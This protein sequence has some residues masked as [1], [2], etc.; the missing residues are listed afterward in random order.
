MAR[1][2]VL[3]RGAPV[4]QRSLTAVGTSLMASGIAMARKPV[5]AK[6][7]SSTPLRERRRSLRVQQPD[8]W[9]KTLRAERKTTRYYRSYSGPNITGSSRFANDPFAQKQYWQ[10]KA[11]AKRTRGALR[12]TTAGAALTTTAR[13]VPVAAYAVV[14]G[15][16][17]EYDGYGGIPTG[18][19]TGR[20]RSDAEFLADRQRSMYR[21]I[22]STAAEGYAAYKALDMI[23]GALT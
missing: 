13:L 5:A 23:V 7:F 20:V 22:R 9:R 17:M 21:G 11:E 1:N 4:V 3:V 19:D 2:Q 15:S 14:L 10:R 18:I 6:K 8:N 12:R 16:Y